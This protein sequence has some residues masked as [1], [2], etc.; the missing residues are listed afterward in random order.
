MKIFMIVLNIAIVCYAIHLLSAYEPMVAAIN[1]VVL[2]VVT[3][4]I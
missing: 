2:E 4:L 3:G 1:R